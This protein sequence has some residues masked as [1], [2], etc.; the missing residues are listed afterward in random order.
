MNDKKITVIDSIMGSGKSTWAIDFINA[1][2]DKNFLYIT[3]YLD[4]T[5]RLNEATN[6]RLIRPINKGRGKLDDIKNLLQA[7]ADIASTHELFKRFDDNCKDALQLNDYTLIIDEALTAVE[8]FIFAEKQDY[9]YLI[10]NGDIRVHPDGMIEWTG[11]NMNTRFDDVR[12]LSQNHCLFKCDKDFF[13][14][15]YPVDIF[16]SFTKVYILTYMFE[17]SLLKS[18]FDLHKFEYDMRSISKINGKYTLKDYHTADKTQIQDLINIYDKSDLNNNFQQKTTNLSS[19]WF[20]SS[21]NNKKI[22]QI[23]NN[24]YNYVT[25]KIGVKSKDVMWTTYKHGRGALSRK[26]YAKGFVACNCRAT[27]NYSAKTCLIY[28]LNCYPQVE[29]EKFFLN[30]NI[31]VDRDKYA[32]AELLQWIWRSAIRNHKK[33]NIYIPSTRM[34]NLLNEWLQN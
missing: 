4:E 6:H 20:K 8:P 7:Q 24:M 19:T 11:E 31:P 21:H 1:N 27:N 13:L 28:A 2:Q 32:T 34:R 33:I 23:K 29:I 14:W 22:E 12:I 9:E 15:Q 18:Y 30:R 10:K 5:D 25:Q 17:G 3:P 26:G 16:L